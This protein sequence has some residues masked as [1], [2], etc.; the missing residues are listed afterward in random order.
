[1]TARRN[2]DSAGIKGKSSKMKKT[3]IIESTTIK[4]KTDGI[5]ITS[6]T[7]MISNAKYVAIK[8]PM[9]VTCLPFMTI[10]VPVKKWIADTSSNMQIAINSI[11]FFFIVY[12]II[13]CPVSHRRRYARFR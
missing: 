4:M 3:K 10:V 6:T 5:I 12:Y 8:P 11:F 1:M 7:A 2:N 9:L 13:K